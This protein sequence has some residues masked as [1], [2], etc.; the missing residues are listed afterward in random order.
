M[1]TYWAKADGDC[2]GASAWATTPGGTIYGTPTTGDTCVLNGKNMTLAAAATFPSS[3]TITKITNRVVSGSTVGGQL[4]MTG[5]ATAN[6]PTTLKAITIEGGPAVSSGACVT[7]TGSGSVGCT[8]TATTI[9]GG[10]ATNGLAIRVS[11]TTGTVTITGTINGGSATGASGLYTDNSSPIVINGSISGQTAHGVNLGGNNVITVNGNI[12]TGT[13]AGANGLY[14]GT[15]LVT[16]N[17]DVFGGGAA[18]AGIRSDANGTIIVN[19]TVTGGSI[20]SA[21]GIRVTASAPTVEV[22][23]AIA[24][25]GLHAYA[26]TMGSTSSMCVVH[27]YAYNTDLGNAIDGPSYLSRPTDA[28]RVLWNTD[29]FVV[30]DA[31]NIRSGK[32]YGTKFGQLASSPFAQGF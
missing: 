30:V 1:A 9:N 20:A 6:T 19:G 29:E 21:S 16:I 18:N 28:A 22:T 27:G 5:S 25:A 12:S 10:D 23:N 14:A 24:G 2:L 15:G 13:T 32:V 17:G 4:I 3:G 26:V 11:G 31:N 7:T 8:I